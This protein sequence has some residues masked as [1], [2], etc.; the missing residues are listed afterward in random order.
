M[1][2]YI[3]GTAVLG[4]QSY[5]LQVM[6]D[7]TETTVAKQLVEPILASG[8]AF[9]KLDSNGVPVEVSET[10]DPK[11][12]SLISVCPILEMINENK[13]Y[14][15]Y[16]QGK[17][18]VYASGIGT[19]STTIEAHIP[20]TGKGPFDINTFDI[21]VDDQ[22]NCYID[23]NVGTGEAG[24]ILS[25]SYTISDIEPEGSWTIVCSSIGT[26][27]YEFTD[28]IPVE[29]LRDAK[30]GMCV[31]LGSS[32]PSYP[33]AVYAGPSF[34]SCVYCTS[35]N[36]LSTPN[37]YTV[38]DIDWILNRP[39]AN[40]V[41]F[42][43]TAYST[44]A[45]GTDEV[46][47]NLNDVPVI[48][49]YFNG[50]AV[51]NGVVEETVGTWHHSDLISIYDLADGPDG[52]CFYVESPHN[53][54]TGEPL[55]TMYPKI[56]LFS[57][58]SVDS[59][60]DEVSYEGLEGGHTAQET[61]DMLLKID[62]DIQYVCFN[63]YWMPN[64]DDVGKI[65]TSGRCKERQEMFCVTATSGDTTSNVSNY[66]EWDGDT[67]VYSDSDE[68][69]ATC[70]REGSKTYYCYRC[71]HEGHTVTT[72][73]L[74][75]LWGTPSYEWDG[76]SYNE[77]GNNLYACSATRV[78]SG[79][80]TSSHSETAQGNVKHN[81]TKAPTTTASGQQIL[82]AVFEESWAATQTRTVTMFPRM[83]PPED[84]GVGFNADTCVVTYSAKNPY[85]DESAEYGDTVVI[86]LYDEDNV[87]IHTTRR[88]LYGSTV[89]THWTE[90]LSS[91][92][93]PTRYEMYM[94]GTSRTL[95]N[96]ETV[97]GSVS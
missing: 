88:T 12:P 47:F 15:F 67:H 61:R 28:F 85:D 65:Y 79:N 23:T 82:T 78:C 37:E 95:S 96:S 84:D 17:I 31:S 92:V 44:Y 90:T 19:A 24:N 71:G 4:V 73:K 9:G 3:R 35:K 58:Y 16:V 94:S 22:N 89:A 33:I 86:L 74:P 55:N 40:Y 75:H 63:R 70:Q 46:C 25:S 30:H 91:S 60:L 34:D 27:K 43:G 36:A 8:N 81:I 7:G 18:T 2:D 72:E 48:Q 76:N 52:W 80:G 77:G 41:I 29:Q 62:S 93:V 66:I 14:Y 59:Y 26:P 53:L 83:L 51:I 20:V 56:V 97:F 10:F 11:K 54:G 1:S 6:Y 57:D 69:L 50:G 21:R 42:C 49:G 5:D 32:A 45:Y 38:N 39:N 68:Q 87:N 64:A 13:Y